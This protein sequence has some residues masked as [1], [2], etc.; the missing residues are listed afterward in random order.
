MTN[1]IGFRK[2]SGGGLFKVLSW[3]LAGRT[4]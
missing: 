4:E 1:L 2:G 3:L